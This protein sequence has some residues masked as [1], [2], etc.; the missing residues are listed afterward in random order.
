M[1]T[2]EFVQ[3]LRHLGLLLDFEV[4]MLR[5]AEDPKMSTVRVERD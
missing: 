3:G 5:H 2:Y 1:L 4:R